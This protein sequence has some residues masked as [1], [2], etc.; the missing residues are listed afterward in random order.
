[1]RK[2]SLLKPMKP[3]CNY[4]R[5]EDHVCLREQARQCISLKALDEEEICTCR[6]LVTDRIVT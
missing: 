4:S 2:Q 5:N 6:Y 3:K 1:M